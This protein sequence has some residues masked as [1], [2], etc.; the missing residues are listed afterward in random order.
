MSDSKEFP[1]IDGG[2]CDGGGCG[3]GLCWCGEYLAMKE[4][5]QRVFNKQWDDSD[6]ECERVERI[7]RFGTS[8]SNNSHEKRIAEDKQFYR[9]MMDSRREELR[10]LHIEVHQWKKG[11]KKL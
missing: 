3:R 8:R 11:I 4:E 7:W 10:N 9:T 6:E 2:W 5:F 1:K